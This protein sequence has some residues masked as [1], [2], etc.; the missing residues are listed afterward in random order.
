[1]ELL[2]KLT[3]EMLANAAKVERVHFGSGNEALMILEPKY[4]G[5]AM[6]VSRAIR[7][8]CCK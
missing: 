6:K 2:N 4:A 7:G 8:W 3:E 1:M 5:I